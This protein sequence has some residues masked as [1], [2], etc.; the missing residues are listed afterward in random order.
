[1]KAGDD[2]SDGGTDGGVA[3][4]VVRGELRLLDR[5]G[6]EVEGVG[7]PGE[8]AHEEVEV[9]LG[10]QQ[11]QKRDGV[12][13]NQVVPLLAFDSLPKHGRGISSA[14]PNSTRMH[15]DY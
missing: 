14:N 15:Q 5:E 9:V 2:G 6:V 11:P 4:V 13:R 8:E 12:L 3:L 7:G 10:R 1:M